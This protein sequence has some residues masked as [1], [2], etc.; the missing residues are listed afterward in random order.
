[1][2]LNSHLSSTYLKLVSLTVL[3][4][5]SVYGAILMKIVLILWHDELDVLLKCV[6]SKIPPRVQ[7]ASG[8]KNPSP[9]DK[10][11]KLISYKDQNLILT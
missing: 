7:S 2:V 3:V 10:S 4:I 11:I 5:H 1:M 9:V 6:D 8:T